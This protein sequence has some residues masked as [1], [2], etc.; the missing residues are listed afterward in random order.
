MLASPKTIKLMLRRSLDSKMFR[1]RFAPP[2]ML[3]TTDV[4]ENL[5]GLPLTGFHRNVIVV[6]VTST[7]TGASGV[8]GTMK[9]KY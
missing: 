2:K 6:V 1:Q 5:Q 7:T 4:H 3:K 9:K 8:A